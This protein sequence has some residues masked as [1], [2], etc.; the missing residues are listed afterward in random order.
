MQAEQTKEQQAQAVEQTAEAEQTKPRVLRKRGKRK[1][2]RVY[3]CRRCP[4][5]KWKKDA[6][7]VLRRP[8][9]SSRMV[10]SEHARIVHGR[11]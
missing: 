3:Y 1:G 9:F 6:K 4:E 10:K 5:E 2:P 11:G 7:G 8:R